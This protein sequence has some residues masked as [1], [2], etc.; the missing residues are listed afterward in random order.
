MAYLI[1][2]AL[3]PIYFGIGL[4]FG[5]GRLRLIDNANVNSLTSLLMQFALPVS[6]FMAI[7]ATPRR[8]ILQDGGFST[9]IILTFVL[10]FFAHAASIPVVI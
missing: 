4:G 2:K 6:L 5:A 8:E 9:L 7:G 1:V 3:L 10:S